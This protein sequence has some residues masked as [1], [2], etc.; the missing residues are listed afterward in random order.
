MFLC[1]LRNSER[2]WACL[3]HCF[4]HVRILIVSGLQGGSEGLMVALY[5]IHM[6]VGGLE[7]GFCFS[8]YW[9]E[10]ITPTEEVIFF[11]GVGIPPTSMCIYIYGSVMFFPPISFSAWLWKPADQAGLLWCWFKPNGYRVR[12][13]VSKLARLPAWVVH[14]WRRTAFLRPQSCGERLHWS[15]RGLMGDATNG[16]ITSKKRGWSYG[17]CNVHLWSSIS[18]KHIYI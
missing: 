1:C 13:G 15:C 5:V 8:I 12:G 7:H 6:L 9:E 2:C 11:R 16:C 4:G 10:Y 18:L 14:I 17:L 3:R